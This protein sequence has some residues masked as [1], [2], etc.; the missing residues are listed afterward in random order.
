MADD[1]AIFAYAQQP[2]V[3]QF[4]TWPPHRTLADSRDFL[5][6]F[7]LENYKRGV[8]DSLGI[9]VK[10]SGLL[11]GTIGCGW[12]SRVHKSMELGFVIAPEQWGRG[13]TTEACLGF[14][15]YCFE[16]FPVE[17]IQA[18][19]VSENLASARVLEKCGLTYEGELRHS[20]Q[21]SKGE[22]WNLKHFSVL[23]GETL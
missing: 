8:P 16:N 12:A 23:R 9:E 20:Y 22:F 13:Y 19:C 10:E 1:Q 3:S 6:S 4:T 7:I 2:V 5:E 15:P 14:L 11:I 21:N 18:R 17:R